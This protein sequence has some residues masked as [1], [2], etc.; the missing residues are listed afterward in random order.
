MS[1]IKSKIIAAVVTIMAIAAILFFTGCDVSGSSTRTFMRISSEHY[2]DIV[3]DTDTK[4]MYSRS[5]GSY[6]RGTL[7]VLV[8]PDGTPKLYDGE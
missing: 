1:S 8:N 7:T 6:N 3:Y 5:M 2:F 4:V